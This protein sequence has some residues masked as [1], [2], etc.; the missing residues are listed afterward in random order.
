VSSK[1]KLKFL[2]CDATFQSLITVAFQ[3]LSN[4]DAEE[5][6]EAK[7]H[8]I[9][10]LVGL[11]AG[12]DCHKINGEEASDFAAY[13]MTEID[14]KGKQL[15]GKLNQVEF[16]PAIYQTAVV[17]YLR[18]KAGYKDQRKL[19]PLVMPSRATMDRLLRETRLYEGFSPKI[20]GNFFDEFV[21]RAPLAIGHLIFDEMKLKTGIFWRTSDHTVCGFASS[22]QNSTIRSVL[23]DIMVQNGD[24]S[25]EAFHDTSAP[26][27]YV[28]QWRF[29][30][31]YNVIHNSNFFFNCG[32]LD[33]NELLIQMMHVVC[34]YEKIGVKIYGI[35]CD[36]CGS[37]RG[38]FKLL[39]DGLKLVLVGV[40]RVVPSYLTFINPYDPSRRIAIFNCSTHN[41]KNVRN[42]LLESDFPSGKRKFEFEGVVFGWTHIRETFERELLGK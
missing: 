23:S 28:N 40:E 34:G 38:L 31:V 3:S 17:L 8:V 29:R 15:A 36:A 6:A 7:Q 26:A 20:Y 24:D 19:S 12:K 16:T 41:L 30:S 10:E 33:G 18:S 11:S 4:L 42:A 2:D 13:L 25:T 21:G 27:V 35:V 9:K 37:K 22:H 32:S 39:R 5:K 14:N 1:A